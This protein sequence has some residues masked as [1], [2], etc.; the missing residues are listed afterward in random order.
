MTRTAVLT[1]DVI[2]DKSVLGYNFVG[3]RTVRYIPLALTAPSCPEV[4]VFH[5]HAYG[6]QQYEAA[7]C[8]V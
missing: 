6:P 5:I 3:A 4:Y 8:Q 2:S 7:E 1:R